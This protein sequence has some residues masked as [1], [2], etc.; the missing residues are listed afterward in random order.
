[1]HVLQRL[2]ETDQF[3]ED[4]MSRYIPALSLVLG[5]AFAIA[6]G[7]QE[8]TTTTKTKVKGDDDAKTVTYT[9][10]LQTGTESKSYMLEKMVPVSKTTTVGT[11]G[12]TTTTTY[13]LVPDE[14]V[15][16]Q[17]MVGHK[18]EVTGMVIPGGDSKTETTT[19]VER[20]GAPDEVTKETTKVKDGAPQ[21]RVTSIRHLAD[22]CE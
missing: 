20:K 21:F 18:V 12:T 6:V 2:I 11:S 19:K 1:M 4:C 17:Q 3:K 14:K 8:T 10:C 7:A 22:K 16:L 9:G 13:A 5:C 15:E